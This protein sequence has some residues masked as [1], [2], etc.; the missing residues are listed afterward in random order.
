[1][2]KTF[3]ILA[4]SSVVTFAGATTLI[5]TVIKISDGDTLSILTKNHQVKKIRLSEIDA[6]DMKQAFG[7]RSKEALSTLCSGKKATAFVLN[8]GRY[9][10]YIARVYCQK[11][12][13]NKQQ[14]LSGLAWVSICFKDKELK[15]LETK[16]RGARRGLW[17]DSN[18][19][20]PWKFRSL[21]KRSGLYYL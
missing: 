13:V 2:L 18:P 15:I 5:G 7:Y 17:N 4:L 6:P 9:G 3:L 20:P 1:M 21:K 16:A 19:I 11:I 8:K 14:I 10:R 12:D